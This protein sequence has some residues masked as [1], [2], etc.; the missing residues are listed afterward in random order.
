MAQDSKISWTTH[1]FN[2]VWGCVKVSPGCRQCYAEALAERQGQS[3]WGPN[4]PRRTFGEKHWAEPLRW[5]AA[6]AAA[7]TRAHVFCSSMCDIGEDHP[8][9][10]TEMAK[11]WPLIRRTPWLDWQ[12][13]TK[14][15]ERYPIILPAD[16]GDGYPNVWLGTSI[17]NNDYVWRADELR[18]L[19]AT[20]RFVS[21]EPALGPLYKLNLDGISWLIYGGESGPGFRDHNLEWARDMKRRCELAGVAFFYKQSAAYRTELET[22]LDG[23]VV[24]NYPRRR[25]PV[26]QGQDQNAGSLFENRGPA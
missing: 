16:W 26:L 11:L 25:L 9:I 8:T 15:P 10:I 3:V 14:R 7:R 23:Q 1:S 12:L 22:E 6:A 20:V 24:K 4:A 21:Y 17:E 2:V 13:L 5:N 18:K 19:P